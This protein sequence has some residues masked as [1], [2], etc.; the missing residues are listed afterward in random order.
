MFSPNKLEGETNCLKQRKQEKLERREQERQAFEER[1]DERRKNRHAV[2]EARREHEVKESKIKEPQV[3]LI[4]DE[5]V[6]NHFNEQK[7]EKNKIEETYGLHS[8]KTPTFSP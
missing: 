7:K 8:T 4:Q 5:I 6:I 1:R 3:D 2:A